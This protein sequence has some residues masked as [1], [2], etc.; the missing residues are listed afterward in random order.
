MRKATALAMIAAACVGCTPR[1]SEGGFDSPDPAAKLYATHRAGE[2]R[3]RSAMPHLVEQLDSD[4]PAVRMMS[5]AAL[6]RITG[7][8]FGYNPYAT[9][10]QRRRATDRWIEAVRSGQFGASPNQEAPGQP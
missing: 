2:Q 6:E 5:I 4:D 9:L 1:A 3:D 10:T 8:R 7:E